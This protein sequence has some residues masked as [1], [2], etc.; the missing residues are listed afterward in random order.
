MA[1][2][3]TT[4]RMHF[5]SGEERIVA[6]KNIHQVGEEG[7]R[8]ATAIV[9]GREIPIYNRVEWGFLWE[10]QEAAGQDYDPAI[11]DERHPFYESGSE[12]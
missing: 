7:A 1:S 9:G 10:V 4:V 8:S 3:Y 6:A 5:I 11:M 12:D 2:E